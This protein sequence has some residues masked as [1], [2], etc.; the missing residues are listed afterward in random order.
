VAQFAALTLAG[1]LL[2][3]AGSVI[4]SRSYAAPFAPQG[5][6]RCKV[7]GFAIALGREEMWKQ[8]NNCL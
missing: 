7:P 2:I 8:R 1:I 4:G 5:A 3:G 6:D